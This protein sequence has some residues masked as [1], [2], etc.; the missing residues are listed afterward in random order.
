PVLY[1]RKDADRFILCMI[2]RTLFCERSDHNGGNTT[3]G[4]KSINSRRDYVIKETA[5]LLIGQ[6][7]ES[8][9]R[10][11]TIQYRIDQF[12]CQLLRRIY[13]GSTWMLVISSTGFHE[14]YAGERAFF[15]VLEIII[16]IFDVFSTGRA[17]RIPGKIVE[18][19]M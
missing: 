18:R 5:E 8:I 12:Y 14:A 17:L 1:K 13:S 4:T 3:S 6:N 7:H 9:V 16:L 15:R 2:D 10:V 19:L 11:R